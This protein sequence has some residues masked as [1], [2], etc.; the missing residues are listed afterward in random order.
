MKKPNPKRLAYYAVVI[1]GVALVASGTSFALD[2]SDHSQNPQAALN[3]NVD[4]NPVDRDQKLANSFAP[5]VH[6]VAPSVVKVSV[7][8]KI[9]QRQMSSNDLDMFR[10]FFG[11][12]GPM[13]PD[14]GPQLQRGLGSG[15][16]V[17]ADGYILT[18]NHVVANAKDVEVTLNDGRQM[19]A[20]VIGTDPKTD[21]ALIKI[22]AN[23]LPTI[24]L[25]DSDK[26]EVGD[27]VLAVGN[28]FGIGQTVTQGIVSAKN[29][30]TSGEGDEDF[31]QTD[32]AINPGNSGGALVDTEGRLVGIN[33]AILTRSGGSQGIGFSVPSNLCRWVTEGLIK[34]GRIDRGFLGVTIQDL[35]PELAKAFKLDR[36]NGA[37][38]G[39]V[40]PSSPA[41][42]AGLK[43]GD[44][45]LQFNGTPV[46]NASQLKLRVAETPP[47]SKVTVQVDRNGENKAVDINVGS[48]PGDK[49][50]KNN[51]N[52]SNPGKETLAGVAVADLD[53][54]TRSQLNIPAGVQG[55]VVSEVSPDSASYEA[56]LRPGDVI[57]EINRKTIK[58][59][60]D[61]VNTTSNG[62]QTLVKV[63]SKG[64]T[65][66][67]TV[68]E[69]G[70]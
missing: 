14:Q 31:I 38:V 52:N 64:G 17:S 27:R 50:A 62:E 51:D 30:A 61:A 48:L 37:L 39:D 10:R 15:V 23:N 46:D 21:V 44:V 18:N 56:G 29:R 5:I 20:K 7:T 40:S 19:T 9:P 6:K 57:L 43:S 45:I 47:G 36:S 24:S 42:N 22:N 35:T 59:A 1:G 4:P 70:S 41:E 16:I 28:P 58:N 67:V 53:A 26:V 32:A 33:S 11:N 60:Q 3:L 34:N 8:A 25:A 49:V 2:S 65:R 63:W 66:F 69:S 68:D 13:M 12:N 54:D 55:A